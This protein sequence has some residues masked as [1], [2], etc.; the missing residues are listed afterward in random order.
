MKLY[1]FAQ[2]LSDN[3]F[4]IKRTITDG[5]GM[6]ESDECHNMYGFQKNQKLKNRKYLIVFINIIYESIKTITKV[7]PPFKS[8]ADISIVKNKRIIFT[9][10]K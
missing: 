4:R 6:P 8:L 1:I 2:K 7:M 10:V 9:A 3:I 5:N